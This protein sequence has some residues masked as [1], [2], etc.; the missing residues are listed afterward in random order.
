MIVVDANVAIKWF[1]PEPGSE[2]ALNLLRNR[3]ALIA[4]EIIRTEVAGAATRRVR[5]KDI[6]DAD[7]RQVLALWLEA[8]KEGVIQTAMPL[9]DLRE[10]GNLSLQLN[11]GFADCLYL[12]FARRTS[13][14]LVTADE[15]FSK[16]ALQVYPKVEL[17]RGSA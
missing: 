10:A 1:I 17:L 9:E 13:A 15:P 14:R 5:R 16:K 8:L 7:A 11:H 6:S 4:P 3:E 2:Q 12:A